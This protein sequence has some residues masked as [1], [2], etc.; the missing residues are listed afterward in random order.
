MFYQPPQET[1]DDF[2]QLINAPGIDENNVQA[3]MEG[4]TEFLITPHLLNHH[5]HFNAVISKFKIGPWS[6]DY[7]YLTKSSDVWR[8]VMVEIEH[9]SKQI[10]KSSKH[11]AFT[12]EFN[13]ALAQVHAWRDFLSHSWPEVQRKILPLQGHMA[14]NDTEFWYVL[15]IG[16]DK[17]TAVNASRRRRLAAYLKNDRMQ[18]LTYDSLIRHVESGTAF[19]KCVYSET[20]TGFSMK[21]LGGDPSNVFAHLR[22]HQFAISAE[23]RA[24]LSAQGYAMDRWAAGDLLVFNSKR[25]FDGLSR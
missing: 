3:F 8:L 12:A 22:P 15:I 11:G 2:R 18:V 17:E 21:N 25:P 16:R 23:Q 1:V 13:D 10:F 19:K 7:S 14:V 6:T 20:A 24:A 4:H 9:P 5:L